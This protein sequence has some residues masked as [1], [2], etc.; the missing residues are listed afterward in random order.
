METLLFY[1]LAFLAAFLGVL[2]AAIFIE[3]S[4]GLFRRKP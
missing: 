1:L 3:W 2:L 4:V